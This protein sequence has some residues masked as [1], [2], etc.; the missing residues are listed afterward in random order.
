MK[1]RRSIKIVPSAE[2]AA[3]DTMFYEGK[4]YALTVTASAL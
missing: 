1:R 2:G 4:P 3:K